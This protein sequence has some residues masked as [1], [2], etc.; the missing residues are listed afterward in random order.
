[1]RLFWVTY[2]NFQH[3]KKQVIIET[4]K[5]VRLLDE[6]VL[7]APNVQKPLKELEILSIKE[8]INHERN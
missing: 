3:A 1:M 4:D 6:M 2:E 7:F 5:P 8:I